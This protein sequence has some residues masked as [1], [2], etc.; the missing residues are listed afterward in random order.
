MRGAAK[1]ARYWRTVRRLRP[2]QVRYR[3][4]YFLK[5]RTD[6][7]FF[8]R[9]L[10]RALR[11]EGVAPAFSGLTMKGADI[12]GVSR[13]CPTVA[14]LLGGEYRFCGVSRHFDGYPAW[15]N[16]TPAER[17]WQYNLH[18]FEYA[19]PLARAWK[20][21]GNQRAGALLCALIDSWIA[22]NPPEA[23]FAWDAGPLSHR[24]IHWCRAA[25]LLG[26]WADLHPE[27][28]ARLA[29]SLFAQALYLEGHLEYHLCGNHLIT[30]A[31][32]LLFAGHTLEGRAAARWRDIGLRMLTDGLD[33][34]M[35]EDGGH[36]ERSP[37]YHALALED[38][39]RCVALLRAAEERPPEPL[40]RCL[41][42]MAAFLHEITMPDGETPLL[43][44]GALDPMPRVEA[45]LGE[46]EQLLGWRPEAR[47]RVNVLA[48]T[49][50][51][52]ARPRPDDMLVFDAGAVGPAHNP[53][54]AHCDTLSFELVLGGARVVVDSGTCSYAA[55]TWREYC[56][57]TRAHNTVMIDGAEQTEK[58]GPWLFRAGR[59]A[60]PRDARM[61]EASGNVFFRAGHDGY[62]H[63][64]GAPKHTRTVA[65]VADRFWLILDEIPGRGEHDLAGFL[66]FH[67]AVQLERHGSG[68]TG[69]MGSNRFLV[70]PAGPV[71]LERIPSSATPPQGWYCPEFG[72]R[73]AQPVLAQRTRGTLPA[74]FGYAIVPGAATAEIGLEVR[75]GGY[76]VRYAIDADLSGTADLP[77]AAPT[78]N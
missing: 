44:D 56:Q 60:H 71:N 3:I 11:I 23:G 16:A 75:A 19:I 17:L 8:P 12:P 53:G 69:Q 33:A 10:R 61:W 78:V 41:S 4:R 63:L 22:E 21:D 6:P 72:V 51:F 49:G 55:D 76:G 40:S 26:D 2:V 39:L 20:E 5:R 43:N 35:L 29:S 67:P 24:I 74:V 57:S 66:H 30:N 48:Q 34:Q 52:L 28:R 31:A 7:F 65:W 13:G 54:H 50:L 27:F 77:G 36:E 1:V 18:Y 47:K 45:L 68:W 59:L 70:V 58:W 46:A 38:G 62:D 64:R 25:L 42:A 15:K 37:M 32:A 14:E 73:A 9:Q